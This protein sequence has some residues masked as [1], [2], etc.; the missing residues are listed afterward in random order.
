MLSQKYKILCIGLG[1]FA[2]V[3]RRFQVAYPGDQPSKKPIITRWRHI[4]LETDFTS[5]VFV[6]MYSGRPDE[7]IE[8]LIF[9]S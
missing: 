7:E 6:K 4:F 3:V 2:E 9:Y 5:V 8:E 1:I